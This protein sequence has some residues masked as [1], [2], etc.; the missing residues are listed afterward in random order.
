MAYQHEHAVRN[1]LHARGEKL[2]KLT[3]EQVASIKCLLSTGEKQT[4]LAKTFGVSQAQISA[5]ATGRSW[6]QA[7]SERRKPKP[8]ATKLPEGDWRPIEGCPNHWVSSTGFIWS[9]RSSRLL[10][11]QKPNKDQRY[12]RVN[13]TT[14]SGITKGFL[15]H[16]LV[17]QAF[18]PK[19]PE[20]CVVDH[21]L[22]F[23]NDVSNLEWTTDH[24]NQQRAQQ[25]SAR[26]SSG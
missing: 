21:K 11:T 20:H 25:R 24:E 19:A 13:L 5:I 16:R 8:R 15:V 14:S 12:V 4:D 9:A 18:L 23:S 7:P 3:A 26:Y 17:A 2:S 22:G 1:K 6:C 10:Q